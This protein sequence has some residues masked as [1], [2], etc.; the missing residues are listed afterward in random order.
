VTIN[1][2]VDNFKL[3]VDKITNAELILKGYTRGSENEE[4]VEILPAASSGVSEH[5]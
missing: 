5:L 3:S 1:A 2:E 4:W